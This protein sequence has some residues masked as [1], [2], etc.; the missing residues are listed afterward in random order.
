MRDEDFEKERAWLI[1]KDAQ[2]ASSTKENS[3]DQTPEGAET[4]V[5]DLNTPLE[6]ECNLECGCCFSPAPFVR[7]P[8]QLA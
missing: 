2:A 4:S 7:F 1:L 6:G 3:Q 8:F 5:V